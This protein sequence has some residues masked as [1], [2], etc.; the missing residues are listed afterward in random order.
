MLSARRG[1]SCKETLHTSMADVRF[2]GIL[3]RRI[4]RMKISIIAVYPYRGE[5]QLDR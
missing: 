3:D 2:E 4:S 1:L 5:A